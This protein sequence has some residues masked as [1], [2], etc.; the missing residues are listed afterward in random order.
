MN[1]SQEK[2]T[3]SERDSIV[4]T[5]EHKLSSN[6]E[7]GY[8]LLRSYDNI[9]SDE[10]K[11]DLIAM[12]WRYSL[13]SKNSIVRQT[14]VNY[15]LDVFY[16]NSS[17]IQG[18]VARF[19]QDYSKQDFDLNAIEKLNSILWTEQS[20]NEIIRIIGIADI[21]T[22]TSDL[23]ELFINHAKDTLNA[24]SYYTSCS[25]AA[26]LALSRFGEH[27]AIN[28]VIENVKNE[29]DIVL[30]ATLLFKDLG[31]TKQQL[32]YDALRS[33]LHSKERLPELK[34]T[35]P[36][37]L[38]ALYAAKVIAGNVRDCPFSIDEI[39]ENNI[40]AFAIWADTLKGW[41]IKVY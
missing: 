41:N 23:E 34:E 16:N 8:K 14:L 4:K 5:V 24:H 10:L 39:N 33:F 26:S 12:T 31:Y 21:R 32:C 27:K 36:G 38:E 3:Y 19:L 1:T 35:L 18:Q 13:D 11:R 37:Q 30:R 20:G 7:E 17:F 15:L 9:E 22:K 29:T 6:W 2:L 40:D 25:W 28:H